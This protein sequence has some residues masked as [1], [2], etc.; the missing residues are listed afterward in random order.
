MLDNITNQKISIFCEKIYKS[1]SNQK[2][3]FLNEDFYDSYLNDK[4]LFHDLLN[5][6]FTDD[7]FY[8]ELKQREYYALFELIILKD[9][10]ALTEAKRENSLNTLN[11]IEGRSFS[12]D[13][14]LSEQLQLHQNI[15]VCVEKKDIRS[16]YFLFLKY[17]N[18]SEDKRHIL[19]SNYD[20]LEY[21]Y[22]KN[23]DN[24]LVE[25]TPKIELLCLDPTRIFDKTIKKTIY[26]ANIDR[27]L[28]SVL[29]RLKEYNL[30]S[31]LSVRVKND[32]KAVFDGKNTNQYL[33]EELDFGKRF[34]LDNIY[35]V[36]VSRLF[37][38]KYGNQLWIKVDSES[39]TFEELYD[40]KIIYKN[41]IVTQMV[42]I[43]YEYIDKKPYIKHF[44]HEFIFYSIDE[45]DKRVANA[46]EK[47][48]QFKRVKSFIVNSASIPFDYKIERSFI[49]SK[50]NKINEHILLVVFVLKK[51]LK[52]HDL[53]DDYFSSFLI[54]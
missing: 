54:Q 18:F 48:K 42:H 29:G 8:E 45:Y 16:F 23:L 21:I 36:P 27:E 30:L 51:Y 41:A 13:T 43:Q 14:F 9:K 34:S 11:Q 17:S 20:Y 22:G 53:I 19:N 7:D 40:E 31:F 39:I 5:N 24:S 6:V 44:D 1:S 46:Y 37:S 35:Q 2:H 26:L 3:T 33:T 52:H 38:Q 12:V 50:G 28:L 32:I 4:E 10:G 49:D 15:F 47:G 25:I